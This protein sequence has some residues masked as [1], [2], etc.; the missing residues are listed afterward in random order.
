MLHRFRLPQ[1]PFIDR[2][3]LQPTLAGPHVVDFGIAKRSSAFQ[4]VL[5]IVANVTTLQ[6]DYICHMLASQCR[7]SPVTINF[8]PRYIKLTTRKVADGHLAWIRGNIAQGDILLALP[9]HQM[10]NDQALEDDGPGR[11]AQSVL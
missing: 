8:N 4:Q 1:Q 5:R 9:N 3:L 2:Q 11:V 10:R 6:L 7:N